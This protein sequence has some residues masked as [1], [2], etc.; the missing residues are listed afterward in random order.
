MNRESWPTSR[1]KFSPQWSWYFYFESSSKS[2]EV[3]SFTC[4]QQK[5][6]LK[7]PEQSVMLLWTVE[8][9]LNLQSKFA[10]LNKLE[11]IALSLRSAQKITIKCYD[12]IVMENLTSS[13]NCE[14][15]SEKINLMTWMLSGSIICVWCLAKI[16]NLFAFDLISSFFL[17]YI[18]TQ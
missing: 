13:L 11:N 15:L 8:I 14:F 6:N 3:R 10:T 18:K 16:M 5:E 17:P 12:V 4:K 7:F 1:R 2:I 9:I